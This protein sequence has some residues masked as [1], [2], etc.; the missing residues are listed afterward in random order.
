MKILKYCFNHIEIW[1]SQLFFCTMCLAVAFQL[2]SR[3]TGMT[4][5]FTEE[6]ARYSYVWVVFACIALAEKQKAHFNVK[7]FTLFLK[8]RAEQV[9]E[10]II[11]IT[12]L[13][14]FSYLFYWSLLYWPFTHV[15]QTP[16]MRLPMTVVTTSLCFG[17]F[18]CFVRRLVHTV[19]RIKLLIKGGNK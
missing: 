6:L 14:I 3:F 10:L 18:M 13:I 8:G 7:A 4:F 16:A 12:C 2:F 15:I 19:N 17:F 5:I 9:L 1:V 11:D